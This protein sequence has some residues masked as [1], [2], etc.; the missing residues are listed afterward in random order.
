MLVL[1]LTHHSHRFPDSFPETPPDWPPQAGVSNLFSYAEKRWG[2]G[3]FSGGSQMR[4]LKGRE[5]DFLEVMQKSKPMRTKM[6]AKRERP[7][8]NP[9]GVLLTFSS[10]S[11]LNPVPPKLW[12]SPATL[13]VP[14]KSF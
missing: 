4:K 6:G 8:H 1:C 14:P 2:R 10:A 3:H 11:I 5:T 12:N 7:L 13:K 9:E